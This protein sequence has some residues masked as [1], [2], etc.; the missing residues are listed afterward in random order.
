MFCVMQLCKEFSKRFPKACAALNSSV[1]VGFTALVGTLFM[2]VR[3]SVLPLLSFLSAF[4]LAIKPGTELFG[5]IVVR[6]VVWAISIASF[7]IVSCTR[8]IPRQ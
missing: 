3:K 1:S 5:D 6:A 4:F 7:G 8:R 2:N